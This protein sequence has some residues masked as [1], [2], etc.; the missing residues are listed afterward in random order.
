MAEPRHAVVTG[1][2]SGIGAAI[3]TRL[4]ADGW[5]ITGLSRTAPAHTV[6]GSHWIPA[7]L[8]RPEILPELLAPVS[9]VDAIVHA[10]GVQRSARLGELEPEDGAL[11]WRIHVQAAGV[12]V[13][14]LVDRIADGGRVVL[15]G[16]RTMTGVPGKSQYAATKAALPALARSWAAEL[17][18]R[19]VTVNVV[20]PGPTDTPMLRDPGRSRT[21]PVLPPL[22]RLVRPEEVAGLTSFL[23][24]PE[25]GAV[26]GQ[27]LVM[28]AGASL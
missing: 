13:D 24:G 21:P 6:A 2:S 26:T 16:S 19:A 8:S 10:A 22:G 7:D 17:A 11:M 23:L 12:L 9:G 5:R 25:G 28:C 1:V 27:T 15:V 20:A 4:L 3:A 14:T 18:P